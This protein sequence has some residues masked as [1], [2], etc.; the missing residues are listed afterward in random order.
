MKSDYI[1]R[2][3]AKGR[4]R[5]PK[6]HYQCC[7]LLGNPADLQIALVEMLTTN[8]G[9]IYRGTRGMPANWLEDTPEKLGYKTDFMSMAEAGFIYAKALPHGRSIPGIIEVW[10]INAEGNY[11]TT[12]Y[13]GNH[14]IDPQEPEDVTIDKGN[15][16]DQKDKEVIRVV[17]D[18][19]YDQI[20]L[21][22]EDVIPNYNNFLKY[23]RDAK[24]HN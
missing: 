23:R 19:I 18:E 12:G 8:C 20:Q 11:D 22:Y 2:I 15:L 9:S 10:V 6:G 4:R 14:S 16:S 5:A 21:N 1:T 24:K 3:S 7:V 13:I 17:M